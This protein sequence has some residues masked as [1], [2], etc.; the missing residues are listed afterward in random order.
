MQMAINKGHHHS[1]FDH[2]IVVV[3]SMVLGSKVL[4]HSNV[5]LVGNMDHSKNRVHNSSL[6]KKEPQLP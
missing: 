1:T 4:P 2:N 6:S 5:V 3:G